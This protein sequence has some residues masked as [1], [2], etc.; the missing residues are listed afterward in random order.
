MKG[1]AL[2]ILAVVVVGLNCQPAEAQTPVTPPP[3]V[4]TPRSTLPSATLRVGSRDRTYS[5]Y[6]PANLPRHAPLLFVFHGA[7]MT[8]QQM[9]VTTGFEFERLAEEQGFVL[10]YPNGYRL[11]WNDCRVGAQLPAK[12]VNVDDVGFV[13]A[14][15]AHLHADYGIDTARVFATGVSNGGHLAYR[16]ALE[17]PTEIR[18]AASVAASLPTADRFECAVPT[19]SIPILIMNGT[20]DPL[21]PYAG[22]MGPVNVPVRSTQATA[23]Y[24]AKLN[25]HVRPPTTTRLPHQDPSDPT[26]VVRTVWSNPG[27]PSVVL[28]TIN[29]GGHLLPELVSR[30]PS[31]LGAVTKDVDGPVEI[32]SFFAQQGS[33]QPALPTTGTNPWTVVLLL[34][35]LGLVGLV[36]GLAVHSR[37]TS[38]TG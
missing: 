17:L 12:D 10:V 13:H 1:L 3:P 31:E 18:A 4:A 24:F 33:E 35:L 7:G 15:I 5:Y 29:G 36:A 20:G 37:R 23:E 9:R 34:W 25:G 28:Y 30:F 2:L 27:K 22:G 32:W 21:N 16:L 19:T 8:D 26:S 38:T 11:T 14:L 6:I